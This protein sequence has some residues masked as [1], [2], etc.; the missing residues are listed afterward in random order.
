MIDPTG[1]AEGGL[2]VLRGGGW[3]DL[4]GGARS[5]DRN[6]DV[7]GNR[8]AYRGFR[9]AR[10]QTSRPSEPEA[11]AGIG[12]SRAGQTTRSGGGQARRGG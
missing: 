4:G 12:A 1:P 8:L 9:L 10:G 11:R 2:R 6:A 7:P 3:F 5:A